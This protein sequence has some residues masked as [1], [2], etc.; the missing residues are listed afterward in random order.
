MPFASELLLG[1]CITMCIFGIVLLLYEVARHLPVCVQRLRRWYSEISQTAIYIR[2]VGVPNFRFF[3]RSPLR[4][5]YCHAHYLTC[6]PS[7]RGVTGSPNLCTKTVALVRQC[8]SDSCINPYSSG[9]KIPFASEL[10]TWG[11]KLP[12][13]LSELYTYFARFH[14]TG[15]LV[16]KDCGTCTAM[17]VWQQYSSVQRVY[18][19]AVRIRVLPL[20]WRTVMRIIGIVQ[21]L[22]E[23][24]QDLPICV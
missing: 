5:V 24:P 18:Q 7:V 15:Q 6:T 23:E 12:W 4:V 13:A 20:G 16:H 22:Y 11:G 1:W 21:L 14:G 9:T 17:Y 2:T 3:Q 10:S 8:K 19:N